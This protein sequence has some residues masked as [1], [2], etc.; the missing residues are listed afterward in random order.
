MT[1]HTSLQ[2]GSPFIPCPFQIAGIAGNTVRAEIRGWSRDLTV[3]WLRGSAAAWP[4]AVACTEQQEEQGRGTKVSSQPGVPLTC[5]LRQIAALQGQA[6]ASVPS[7]ILGMQLPPA[8]P[9]TART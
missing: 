6:H 3:V 8:A 9:R 7:G 5:S 2:P 4:E 1:N